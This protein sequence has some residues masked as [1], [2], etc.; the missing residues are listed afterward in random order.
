MYKIEI[1]NRDELTQD[2]LEAIDIYK[3]ES[4]YY[5]EFLKDLSN[6][7]NKYLFTIHIFSNPYLNAVFG[8]S[9]S[10]GYRFII[11]EEGYK[12]LKREKNLKKLGL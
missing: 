4:D 9:E 2:M 5:N 3:E 8:Y 10:E 11:N 1:I 12:R 6:V 7:D